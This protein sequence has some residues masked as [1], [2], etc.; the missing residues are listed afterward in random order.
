MDSITLRSFGRLQ[1]SDPLPILVRLRE[2]ERGLATSDTPARIRN[3][4]TNHL[5]RSREMREA[6]IFCHLV[7]QRLGFTVRFALA[8]DQD[9]DFVAAWSTQEHSHFAPVQLKELPPESTGSNATFQSIVAAL[10]AHYPASKE[11]V[12][13]IHLNRRMTIDFAAL[14][15]PSMSIAELWAFGATAADQNSW[16]LW[17]DLLASPSFST[18]AYPA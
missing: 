2:I 16:G 5:K 18:H 6:A 9:F 13:A 17:G 14:E 11:L 8:E 12:V 10:A 4:R 1:Y 7:G 15:I 3:L